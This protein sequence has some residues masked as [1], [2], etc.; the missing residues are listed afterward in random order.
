MATKTNT[1]QNIT[2]IIKGEGEKGGEYQIEVY[3]WDKARLKKII[4][5]QSFTYHFPEMWAEKGGYREPGYDVKC[6][7]TSVTRLTET[8]TYEYED[9]SLAQILQ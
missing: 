4:K 3:S 9:I 7:V 8:K 2:Y 5:S 1:V 6:K